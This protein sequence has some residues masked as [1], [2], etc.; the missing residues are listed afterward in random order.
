LPLAT[1]PQRTPLAELPETNRQNVALSV[2]PPV[3][4]E[5]EHFVDSPQLPYA[6]VRYESTD[7]LNVPKSLENT[8]EY[9]VPKL[10]AKYQGR[11]L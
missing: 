2:T 8:V 5:R 7:D 6:A 1:L 10:P 3:D 9:A 11:T 4:W